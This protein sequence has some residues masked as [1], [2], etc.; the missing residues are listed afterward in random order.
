MDITV[1]C[2][3]ESTF[4]IIA[5]VIS[6]IGVLVIGYH[7]DNLHVN[8]FGVDYKFNMVICGLRDDEIKY[9]RAPHGMS[10]IT[11]L[12]SL[13]L[14]AILIAC[15]FL[16]TFKPIIRLQIRFNNSTNSHDSP[17][18]NPQNIIVGWWY[19]TTSGLIAI[20]YFIFCILNTTKGPR[21]F[22][23]P[24]SNSIDYIHR[25]LFI[26][27]VSMPPPK[28]FLNFVKSK[29]LPRD[30][31]IIPNSSVNSFEDFVL[32]NTTT[33]PDNTNSNIV[34]NNHGDV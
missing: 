23:D 29:F 10:Y 7:L 34:F 4:P 3:V 8:Y 32:E 31:F 16:Y 1:N 17:S 28:C 12:I 9:S 6:S 2:D 19:M 26:L 5:I 21:I 13:T 22:Y 18:I 33:N 30:L 15:S 25:T 11:V 14:G 24:L 20:S 27:D